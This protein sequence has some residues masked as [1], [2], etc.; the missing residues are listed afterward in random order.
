ML[1]AKSEF[2]QISFHYNELIELTTINCTKA[3]VLEE[4]K[5]LT[6]SFF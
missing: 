4:S 5:A 1:F 3:T 2:L 6:L